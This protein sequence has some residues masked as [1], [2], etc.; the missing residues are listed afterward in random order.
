MARKSGRVRASEARAR[1]ASILRSS[2]EELRTGGRQSSYSPPHSELRRQ[3]P[4][5]AT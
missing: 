3:Q 2:S 4:Q 1:K 5:Q